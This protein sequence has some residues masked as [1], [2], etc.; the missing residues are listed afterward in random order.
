[1]SISNKT[2][3]DIQRAIHLVAAFVLAG[4]VYSPAGSDP[5]FATLTRAVV[6]PVLTLSGLLIWKLPQLRRR[7]RRRSPA[8]VEGS[9][10]VAS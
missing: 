8:A 4:Y 6:F 7:L 5:A 2:L 1:M 9:P 10:A 3:R